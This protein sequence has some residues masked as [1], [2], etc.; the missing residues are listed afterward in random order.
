MCV[1][2]QII[3]CGGGTV[4]ISAFEVTD[5]RAGSLK[6]L[7]MADGGKWG[8][9]NV[10][11]RFASFLQD[12]IKSI[13][14]DVGVVK[15]ESFFTSSAWWKIKQNWERAKVNLADL[16][17]DCWV[18]VTPLS[19]Q[20][21]NL[22][23]AAMN[24]GRDVKNQEGEDLVGGYNSFEFAVKPALMRRFFAPECSRV[25]R[26]VENQLSRPELQGLAAVVMVGGF[27]GSVH[28]R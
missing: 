2:T 13:A 1:W 8:A 23:M 4:D 3:D 7:G 17:G 26:A 5:G 25:K 16:N 28:V 15:M 21:L 27:S 12:F 19:R 9:T 24:H 11:K 10:D 18:N 22:T 6:Q 14:G 20:P